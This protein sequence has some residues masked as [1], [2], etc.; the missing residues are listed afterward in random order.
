MPYTYSRSHIQVQDIRTRSTVP[1][2]RKPILQH[3]LEPKQR[4]LEVSF[5]PVWQTSKR[6]REVFQGESEG[7]LWLWKNEGLRTQNI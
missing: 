2:R 4:H 3:Q 6:K 5:C 1:M 7:L